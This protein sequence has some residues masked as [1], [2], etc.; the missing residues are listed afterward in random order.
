M[1]FKKLYLLILILLSINLVYSTYT[2]TTS[3][4]TIEYDLYNDQ[5]NNNPYILNEFWKWDFDE[6]KYLLN[7]VLN[8]AYLCNL[9]G[10]GCSPLVQ[11]WIDNDDFSFI[12]S[13]MY[14]NLN[15]HYNNET[16]NEY[17]L[18]DFVIKP[19]NESKYSIN[20]I[21]PGANICNNLGLGCSPF[22]TKFV[23][24]NMYGALF[25]GMSL[26]FVSYFDTSEVTNPY[27]ILPT[28]QNNLKKYNLTQI[29]INISD[30]GNNLNNCFATINNENYSMNYTNNNC[31]YTHNITL[32]NTQNKIEFQAFYNI[33]DTISSLDK[34]TIYSYT[35]D[36]KTNK[37]PAF[38][39]TSFIFFTIIIIGAGLI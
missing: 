5:I 9:D 7:N 25:S 29:T 15:T 4:F 16:W 2:N 19:F 39:L 17:I 10:I 24:G 31:F 18:N 37:L 23:D 22:S 12:E 14:L 20:Y 26:K 11:Q 13:G 30:G 32:N 27:Y 6:S 21:S 8:Y 28:P 1:E 33:S 36:L 34:R 3:G 38:S 35:K